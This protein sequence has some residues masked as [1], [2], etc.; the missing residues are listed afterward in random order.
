[1]DVAMGGRVAE[2]LFFGND[3]I[4]TGCGSDLNNATKQA[5]QYLMQYDF[6]NTLYINDIDKIST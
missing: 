1:M 3:Q 6:G 5:Y 2:D 4:T